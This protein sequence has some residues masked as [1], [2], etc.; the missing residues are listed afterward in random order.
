[1]SHANAALIPRRL[2]PIEFERNHIVTVARDPR[3]ID[4][5]KAPARRLVCPN[6]HARAAM[7]GGSPFPAGRQGTRAHNP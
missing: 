1:M 6:R 5:A 4:V 3:S 2:T 7:Q